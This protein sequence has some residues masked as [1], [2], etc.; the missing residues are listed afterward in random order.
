MLLLNIPMTSEKKVEKAPTKTRQPL[1]A[2]CEPLQVHR[3]ADCQ[4]NSDNAL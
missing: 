1:Q 3:N 4:N 2:S